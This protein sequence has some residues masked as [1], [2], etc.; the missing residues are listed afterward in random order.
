[1]FSG[2]TTN[3]QN[4]EAFTKAQFWESTLKKRSFARLQG[5]KPEKLQEPVPKPCAS[6]HSQ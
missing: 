3:V 2:F 4:K 6:A 1:M 5:L